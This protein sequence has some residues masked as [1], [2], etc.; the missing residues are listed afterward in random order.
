MM[1]RLSQT[2][3]ELSHWELTNG[4]TLLLCGW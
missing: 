1:M 4:P 2:F 3:Q